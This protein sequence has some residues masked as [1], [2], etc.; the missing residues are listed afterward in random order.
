VH[1]AQTA[2]LQTNWQEYTKFRNGVFFKLWWCEHASK[3]GQVFTSSVLTVG[4]RGV[5][6]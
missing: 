3:I 1:I 6:K 4:P 5:I 2:A